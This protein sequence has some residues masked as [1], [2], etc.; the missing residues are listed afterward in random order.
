MSDKKSK[1]ARGRGPQRHTKQD[2]IRIALDT[3]ISEGVENVKVMVLSDKMQTA[4]SSFYWHFDSRAD[5]LENLLDHWRQT[6]TQAIVTSAAEP[7]DTITGAIVNVYASWVGSGKFDTRLDFAVRDWARRSGSVRRALDA[8]DDARVEALT[9]MFLRYD[10]PQSE[11]AVRA[12][13][14]YYTQIGYEALDPQESWETRHT[15]VR[16]YLFCISGIEPTAEDIERSRT[17]GQTD[18]TSE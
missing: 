18:T 1:K 11:A 14:L 12:R 6:N 15:R 2:W 13:I 4:R 3:L 10:Y 17:L 5:L 9:Q 8:S 16:D 7:A